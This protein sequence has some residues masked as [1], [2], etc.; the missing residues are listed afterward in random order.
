[1]TVNQAVNAWESMLT[2][3]NG[4]APAASGPSTLRSP[5]V[6]ALRTTALLAL[7]GLAILVLLPAALAAQAAFAA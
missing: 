2:H 1:M 6:V 7:A 5:V 3:A 4:A